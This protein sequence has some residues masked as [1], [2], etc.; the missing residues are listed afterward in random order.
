MTRSV[1]FA[2]CNPHATFVIS[3][4]R[5][6]NMEQL[7]GNWSH[8]TPT[9]LRCLLILIWSQ[10]KLERTRTSCLRRHQEG[11]SRWPIN[12]YL[13]ASQVFDQSNIYVPSQ[14][15]SVEWGP[16]LLVDFYADATPYHRLRHINFASR[17]VLE[18]THAKNASRHWY[19]CCVSSIKVRTFV[20]DNPNRSDRGP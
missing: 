12:V 11:S 17:F 16:M 9:L 5:A 1:T 20:A 18:R 10:N 4:N 3:I 6:T 15:C 7:S 8:L 2:R 19:C 14:S 13:E